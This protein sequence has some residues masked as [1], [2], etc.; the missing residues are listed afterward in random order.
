MTIPTEVL[1][2]LI[3]AIGGAI[4][5]FWHAWSKAEAECDTCREARIA[6]AKAASD[7]LTE[8]RIANVGA[9]STIT[10]REFERDHYMKSHERCE[11]ELVHLRGIESKGPHA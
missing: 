4:A 11:R 6:E 10:M 1:I 9:L 7:L 2:A 5:A 3:P 8:Q